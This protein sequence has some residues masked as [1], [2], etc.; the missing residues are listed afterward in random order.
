MRSKTI[1]ASMLAAAAALC[2]ISCNALVGAGAVVVLGGVGVL[3]SQCYDRVQVRVIDPATGGTTCDADVTVADVDGSERGVRP[4]YN[5]ALTEGRWRIIARRPGY[6]PA[7]SEISIAERDGACPHYVHSVQL[8]MRREG[9]PVTNPM[10]R[11]RDTERPSAT[12]PATTTELESPPARLVPPPIPGVPTKAF[13]PVSPGSPSPPPS[14]APPAPA[15]PA[16]APPAPAPPAPAPPPTPT[17]S[18]G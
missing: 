3:A 5:T 18:N 13:E 16:P 9:E 11:S 17:P 15:P 14:A 2:L 12:P 1:R 10:A 8:T 7:T 6:V 4:C